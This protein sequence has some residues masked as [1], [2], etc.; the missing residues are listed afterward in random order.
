MEVDLKDF[1]C[2]GYG[3]AYFSVA[4]YSLAELILILDFEGGR[5]KESITHYLG[6]R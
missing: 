1:L 5:K 2:V 6:L 4:L 3:Q